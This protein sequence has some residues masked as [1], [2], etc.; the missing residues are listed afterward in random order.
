MRI[1]TNEANFK[2]AISKGFSIFNLK[3][4]K[5]TNRLSTGIFCG[6]RKKL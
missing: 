2:L 6:N 4:V 3:P 1:M 5:L